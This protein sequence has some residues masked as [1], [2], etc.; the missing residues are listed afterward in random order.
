MLRKILIGLAAL[1]LIG[2]AGLWLWTEQT[3]ADDLKLGDMAP[4]FTAPGA[5]DGKRF[6]FALKDALAKG[7]VVLYFFPKVFT[8][9]CTLE[10]RAFAEATPQFEAMGASIVGMSADDIGGISRFSAAECRD[11]FPL[12]SASPDI[13][14]DYGVAMAPGAPM[15]DRTSFVIAPDGRI[16]HIHSALD[17]KLHVSETLAAVRELTEDE[18]VSSLPDPGAS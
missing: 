14:A 4:D 17:Y 6:T 1:V 5:L 13:I 3:K 16:A 9:G 18:K 11:K 2:G 12:A 8:E 7:P 15:T 10:T